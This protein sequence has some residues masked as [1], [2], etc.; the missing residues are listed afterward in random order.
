MELTYFDRIDEH[1]NLIGGTASYDRVH[2]EGLWHRGVHAIIYTPDKQIVMQKRSLSLK[3]HPGEIEVSVGG[4]IDAGETPAQAMLREIKEELGLEL[5][6]SDLKFIG[7]TKSNHHTKTQINR[8]FIYSYSVCLPAKN[9]RFHINEMESSTVFFVSE[10][11]LRRALKL[12]RIK[13]IGKISSLYAYWT[14]LL[15]SI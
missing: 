4:G 9:L 12:H 14:K 15:N 10:K 1:D 11:K 13:K 3:Y 7:K 6:K 2:S 8:V 5:A